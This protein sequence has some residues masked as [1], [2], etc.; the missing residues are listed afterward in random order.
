MGQYNKAI[1]TAAGEKL[2]ARALAGEIQLNITK[3][4]TSNYIYPAGTDFKLI[5]DMQG[6]KQTVAD[7]TTAVYDDTMIQTRVLFSNEE[8]L[9]TYYIQNIGLYAM[10]GTEEVLFCIVTAKTPDEMPQYSGVA[11]TSYIYNIQNVVQDA[12]QL[13]ITVNPSGTATIQDVLER[14]D[15]TG[16]DI[17][18]TVI[19]TL[20]TVE[21][22]F[23]V[24]VAGE[25]VKRFFGKV[26]T[27]LRNIKPLTENINIYV[28]AT[29]SDTTG[30]GS[31]LNP[32]KTIQFA[33][34]SIP[35]DLGGHTVGINIAN[36]TYPEDM[37]IIGFSNGVFQIYNGDG[38]TLS[39]N[40]KVNSIYAFCNTSEIIIGGFSI[41]TV[42]DTGISAHGC[43][44]LNIHFT[45][46]IGN[47]LASGKYGIMVNRC[48][49]SIWNCQVSYRDIALHAYNSR[50][51]SNSWATCT[52]NN[53]GLW[54]SYGSVVTTLGAQPAATITSISQD[55]GGMYVYANGSQ[56]AG[57]F[58]GLSCTWGTIEGGYMRHG[59]YAN[60][61]AMITIQMLVTVTSGLTAGNYYTI[62]GVPL[63]AITSVIVTHNHTS[64]VGD[65]Y[66]DNG[67]NQ[68]RLYV[69]S[70]L[71]AGTILSFSAT[72]PTNS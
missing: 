70:N 29:G 37:R 3:A 56:I 41:T 61:Q 68:M 51:V 6:I 34:D 17:S 19:E 54:S 23:P 55:T 58:Q 44:N 60:G 63:P 50:G 59:M 22:K 12:D 4:K 10:D 14:V 69:I 65:C 27:F 26:L 46:I 35:K 67:T 62:H 64:A 5:T 20:N 16:G 2:I 30:D 40:C 11:S 21:D 57:I 18:E 24:P 8:I 48:A 9:S 1:L 52:G 7:P 72:Y 71:A 39:D 31:E 13:S 42:T 36:G 49:F 15:A 38:D 28:S 43:T 33:I 45:K 32:Y 66:V 53:Y 47:A 25:S